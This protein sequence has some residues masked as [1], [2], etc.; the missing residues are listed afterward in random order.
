V[1]VD[2]AADFT[3]HGGIFGCGTEKAAVRRRFLDV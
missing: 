1:R 3:G 2:E